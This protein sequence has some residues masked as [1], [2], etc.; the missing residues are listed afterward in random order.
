GAKELAVNMPP[1]DETQYRLGL[2]VEGKVNGY[3]LHV[4]NERF[5]RQSSICIR[6][7]AADRSLLDEQGYSS[8]YIA[9]DGVIAGLVPYSDRLRPESRA[10]LL[11]LHDMGVKHRAMLTGDNAVVARAVGR[12]LGLTRIFADMLPAD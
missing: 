5:M 12:Q 4:G 10:V 7:T 1:C 6:R 3:Y 8:L 2:G 11:R 9:V